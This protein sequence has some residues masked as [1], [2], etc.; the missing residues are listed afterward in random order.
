[1]KINWHIKNLNL[2]ILLVIVGI[3]IVVVIFY[4]PQFLAQYNLFALLLT[5]AVLVWYAYDT[6]RI[7]DQTIESNLRPLILR[8]G[9]I[10]SWNEIKFSLEKGKLE[11]RPLEF[12]ILK[13]IAKDIN[14]YIIIDNKKYRFLFA[15]DISG[16]DA[17]SLLSDLEKNVL[18]YLYELYKIKNSNLPRAII[19]MYDSIGVKDGEYVGMINNSKY[20]EVR[21]GDC[22]LTDEGIRLMDSDKPMEYRFEPNWGWM[23][24]G[25]FIN[26]IFTSDKYEK[27]KDENQI[28]LTYRDVEG[29]LYFTRENKNFSQNS[30]KL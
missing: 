8:S 29:N 2:F 12:S 22:L 25:T 24:K 20:I 4:Y 7:A 13:N 1:M 5:L 18:L 19:A 10:E 6:H 21:G 16:R 27:C 23:N 9:F 28:Y 26:A 11:G 30:G 15:N 14:G 17:K 3:I